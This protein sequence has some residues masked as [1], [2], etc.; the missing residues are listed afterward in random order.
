MAGKKTVQIEA[1]VETEDVSE[2]SQ[3]VETEDDIFIEVDKLQELG[4]N[5]A[6]ITKL[7]LSGYNTALSIIQATRKELL[8]IKGFSDAKVEKIIECAQKIEQTDTFISG[9]NLLKKRSSLIKITTGCNALDN[10]LQGGLEAGSMTEIFGENRTGKTQFCHTLC[11]TGQLPLELSGGNGKICYI[12]TEGTF[13]PEKIASICERFNLDSEAVLDNILYARAHN[14]EHLIQLICLASTKMV[15]EPFSLLVIDGIM[16]LFRVDF[17]GRGEL[18][19]RQ[20]LLGKT[21]NRL[22]K[23]ADQ[24]NIAIVYT[25]Q[26]MSDPSGAMTMAINPVKPVGGHVLGHASTHRLMFRV[27]KGDQR[28][29]KVYDSPILPPGDATFQLSS[30]GICDVNE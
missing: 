14:H 5:V 8:A 16:S 13:R 7:K 19:E 4:I 12:D 30:L 26:V 24:F 23:L 9:I 28:V 3:T 10:L 21:L 29:C 2:T 17:S 11:V 1:E 22:Q 25:N 27:G 20:Q 18:S 6:D 15:L